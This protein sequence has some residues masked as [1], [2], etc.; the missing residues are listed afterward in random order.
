MFSLNVYCATLLP[1]LGSSN[2][3]VRAERSY[4]LGKLEPEAD[5]LKGHFKTSNCA[6]CKDHQDEIKA[7]D[8]AEKGLISTKLHSKEYNSHGQGNI[9][10]PIFRNA[11]PFLI[12]LLQSITD[13]TIKARKGPIRYHSNI[14]LRKIT[15]VTKTKT[16][17]FTMALASS[18]LCIH[19][20]RLSTW[21]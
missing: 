21:G 3:G 19:G 4:F 9:L 17:Q 2:F 6:V 1:F 11:Q 10:V 7:L 8:P 20:F 14:D 15:K 16:L 13:V 12:F 18:N 5:V